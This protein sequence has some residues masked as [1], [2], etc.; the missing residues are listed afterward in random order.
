MLD[1]L[2][3]LELVIDGLDDT[4]SSEHDLVHERKE[5]V[6]HVFLD[7]SDEL[8][9]LVPERSKQI[10]GDISPIAKQ[11]TRHSFGEFGHGFDVVVWRI[12]RSDEKRNKLTMLI[13][14]EV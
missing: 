1:L 9:S 2:Y 13:D 6:L 8:R 12:A 4:S 10:L 7:A 14:D 11:F 3:I 5:F